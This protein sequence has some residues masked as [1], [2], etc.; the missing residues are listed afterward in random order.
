MICVSIFI[1]FYI[2]SFKKDDKQIEKDKDQIESKL[3][4]RKKG[5]KMSV[6]TW[7]HTLLYINFHENIPITVFNTSDSFSTIQRIK[8]K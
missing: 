7:N 8:I 2:E 4:K 6:E 1:L 5:E 3:Q